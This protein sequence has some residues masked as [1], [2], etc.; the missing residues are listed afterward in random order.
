MDCIE[1]LKMIPDKSIDLILTDPPYGINQAEWD[2]PDSP[3]FIKEYLTQFKRV[4]KDG[5]PILIFYVNGER[6]Q[7]FRGILQSFGLWPAL[8][9]Y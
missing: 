3:V 6:L 4:I 7:S 8:K 5:C 2:K 9:A 1:G